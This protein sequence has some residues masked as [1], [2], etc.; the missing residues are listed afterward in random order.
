[1]IALGLLAREP[2]LRN[3][4]LGVENPAPDLGTCRVAGFNG[5]NTD[6][7][8]GIWGSLAEQVGKRVQ[9]AAYISPLLSAP[10]PEAWKNLLGGDPL[11]LFLDELPPYL[12]YAA[13]VPVGNA[14]LSIVT[15]S[16]SC[17]SF[18]RSRRDG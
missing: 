5:R 6:A 9:F 12:E 17:Q 1:M 3:R 18:Y 11:V 7:S 4:V 2:N 10:G 14:D 13:A 15:Y 8:G 16:G